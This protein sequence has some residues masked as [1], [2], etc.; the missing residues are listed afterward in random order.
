VAEFDPNNTA[1]LRRRRLPLAAPSVQAAAYA[2]TP[3]GIVAVWVLEEV[4]HLHVPG[5]VAAAIG[6]ILSAAAAF[7]PRG[8]RLETWTLD[9]TKKNE[10][11]SLTDPP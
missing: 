9:P 4:M 5:F 11:R 3:A 10:E 2:G 7:I 8:G 1:Q 6:S